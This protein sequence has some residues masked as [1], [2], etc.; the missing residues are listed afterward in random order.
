MQ[1][2]SCDQEPVIMRAVASG[3][4]TPQL[5][6]HAESCIV[7][8]AAIRISRLLQTLSEAPS[9]DLPPASYVWWRTRM[10]QRREAQGRVTRLIA[11]T[12]TATF[13]V[14]IAGLAIWII[15]YWSELRDGIK[16]SL[17]SFSLWSAS[18]LTSGTIALVYVSL[19]LLFLNVLLTVRAVQTGNKSG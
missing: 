8:G 13:A 3:E 19:A 16:G 11:I 5:Q 7:C 10:R 9:P 17:N 15:K 4:L 14:S 12:Q 18:N 2:S 6:A 1:A